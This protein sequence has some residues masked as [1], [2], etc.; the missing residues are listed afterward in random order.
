VQFKLQA[1]AKR[2]HNVDAI[3]LYWGPGGVGMSLYSAHLHAVYGPT[4]HRYFDPNVF[5]ADDE[6]RKQIEQLSGAI[7]YTGQE[8]PTGTRSRMREDLLKKFAT[9][10]GISG[11]MPYAILTKQFRIVGW[12]RMEMNKLIQFDD[13][14]AEN[15]ESIMR[16]VAL[17]KIQARFCDKR[18]LGNG[19]DACA[20][21]GIFERDPDLQEF[22][23][24]TQ[25]Q[26]REIQISAARIR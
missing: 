19:A 2:G 4:N 22:V 3:T 10:E 26:V 18:V 14:S 9:A 13:V 8:K 5:Y 11:R 15:F 1:L 24:S 12:K 6:L 25:A 7:I 23:V 17:V 21:V 16:R 20:S